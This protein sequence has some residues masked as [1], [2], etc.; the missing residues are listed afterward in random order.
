MA[1][2][3]FICKRTAADLLN[4]FNFIVSAMHEIDIGAAIRPKVCPVCFGIVI[5]LANVQAE[6]T[7]ESKVFKINE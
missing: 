4:E 6:E 7:Y 1:E 5:S 3:C 2:N